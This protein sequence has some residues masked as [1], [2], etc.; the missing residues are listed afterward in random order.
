MA[1]PKRTGDDNELFVLGLRL[2]ETRSS[3]I[4]FVCIGLTSRRGSNSNA[5]KMDQT[6]YKARLHFFML[7]M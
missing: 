1:Q 2:G 7:K 3:L 5:G 4:H 6:W